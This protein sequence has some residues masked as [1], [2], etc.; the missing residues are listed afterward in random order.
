MRPSYFADLE[1]IA[2]FEYVEPKTVKEACALLSQQKDKAKVIAGGTRLLDAI[3][4]KAVSPQYLINLKSVPSLDN[5]SFS[6]EEGL[7][8]GALATLF[9]IGRSPLVNDKAKMVAEAIQ[10]REITANRTRWAYY[11]AT[12]GGSLSEAVAAADILP[13]LI[14]FRAKAVIEGPKGWKTRSLEDL[15]AKSGESLLQ[16]DEVLTEIRIPALPPEIGV[17]YIKSAGRPPAPTVRAATLLKLDA[18]HVDTEDFRIVIGGVG[19]TPVEPR[20]AEEVLIGKAIDNDLIDEAI[21][22]AAEEAGAGA[23]PETA[24]RAREVIEE[25]IRQAVDLAIGDFALGY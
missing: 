7:K 14:L 4:T 22:K 17:M 2:E 8:I 11:M 25:A 19:P 10:D 5:I 9:D 24:E 21:E 6:D 1:G 15:F 12:L 18:K 20:G 16:P 3:R 23:E 13:P